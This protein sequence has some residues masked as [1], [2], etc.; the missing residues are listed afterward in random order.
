[1]VNILLII[2]YLSLLAEL[3]W[4]SVPSPASTLQLQKKANQSFYWLLFS[5]L[6]LMAFLLPLFYLISSFFNI[7]IFKICSSKFILTLGAFLIIT[8]RIITFV[9]GLQIKDHIKQKR[10]F[11][12]DV[13][14]FKF[15]RHP[16]ALGLMIALVGLN[17]ILPSI[18]MLVLSVLFIFDLHRKVLIEEKFLFYQYAEA[19]E[20]YCKKTNR[21][22]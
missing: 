19:Y 16:I 20:N 9:G 15:S 7:D 11:I 2:F 1:M 8:G 18:I 4:F 14:L 21:Y 6:G 10:L 12:L 22:L 3:I 17:F 13:G 5:T